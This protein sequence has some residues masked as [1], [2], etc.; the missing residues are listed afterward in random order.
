GSF[1]GVARLGA[2]HAQPGIRRPSPAGGGVMKPSVLVMADHYLPGT[3][4]GG[5][6][7]SIANLVDALGEEIDFRIVTRDRDLGDGAPYP[8][9]TPNT[10]M[11][12]GKARVVYLSPERLSPVSL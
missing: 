1:P 3:K 12:V 10:W 9:V 5:P 4:G 6:I 8:S 7:R 11:E 2:I